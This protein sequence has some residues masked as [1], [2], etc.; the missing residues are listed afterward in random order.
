MSALWP[1]LCWRSWIYPV[2]GGDRQKLE[3]HDY[4]AA[5]GASRV[6]SREE[7]AGPAKA[8]D[9]QLWAGAIDTVGSQLRWPR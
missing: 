1:S 2:G 9:K 5:L 3:N 6:L 8:L 4:L 7:W